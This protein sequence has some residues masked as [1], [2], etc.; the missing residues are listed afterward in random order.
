MFFICDILKI[1]LISTFFTLSLFFLYNIALFIY[2]NFIYFKDSVDSLIFTS[3]T[4]CFPSLCFGAWSQMNRISME[5][6]F[7]IS[8]SKLQC[9]LIFNV[10]NIDITFS[11]L[12]CIS[13]QILQ[14]IYS[15][16]M[17]WNI[18][19]F[20]SILPKNDVIEDFLSN[21]FF[22]YL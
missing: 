11:A 2:I 9:I 12:Q 1:V 15:D 16:I 22:L 20:L 19:K 8:L 5:N 3:F 21:L 18:K 13:C 10:K 6:T 4:I 17:S 14:N 7:I